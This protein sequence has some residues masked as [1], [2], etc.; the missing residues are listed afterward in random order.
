MGT[1]DN[2]HALFLTGCKH[3]FTSHAPATHYSVKTQKSLFW[4]I[5]PRNPSP[6]DWITSHPV[7]TTYPF[8]IWRRFCQK[9][10]KKKLKQK[11]EKA[12]LTMIVWQWMDQG[13]RI[14]KNLHHPLDHGLSHGCC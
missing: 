13:G 1:R 5:S 4:T 11:V 12:S 14:T 7:P 8:G 3:W 9:Y 10:A 2:G 6:D